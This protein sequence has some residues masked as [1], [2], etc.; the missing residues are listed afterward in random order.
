MGEGC[1]HSPQHGKRLSKSLNTVTCKERVEFPP[2]DL[3]P[4]YP[5][6]PDNLFLRKIILDLQWRVWFFM[7]QVN[8]HLQSKP[9][10][11]K[12]VLFGHFYHKN[13]TKTQ[14]LSKTNLIGFLP[15][16]SSSSIG[17]WMGPCSKTSQNLQTLFSSRNGPLPLALSRSVPRGLEIQTNVRYSNSE[18][19][20]RWAYVPIIQNITPNIQT[21]DKVGYFSK[22]LH[23]LVIHPR[24][25]CFSTYFPRDRRIEFLSGQER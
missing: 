15:Y 3:G 18:M 24:S 22:H 8:I 2:T 12:Y 25:G 7:T 17:P 5:L 23:Y 1:P 14:G 10:I 16:L 11:S 4:L 20:K 21:A 19:L 13:Q 6:I 9:F